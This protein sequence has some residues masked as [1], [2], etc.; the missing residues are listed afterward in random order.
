MNSS[1][2]PSP[3][4]CPEC[5]TRLAARPGGPICPTCV[6]KRAI[7]PTPSEYDPDVT[8]SMEEAAATSPAPGKVSSPRVRPLV[9]R[10]GS[11]V[12][13]GRGSKATS[14]AAT[15]SMNAEELRPGQV[16]GDYIIVKRL[17]HGGM[18]TVY[19]ADHQ[20]T[21][22][23]VALKVLTHAL[24]NPQ[25]RARF[26]REGRLAASINHP[27]SVYV[28]GTEEIGETPSISME[29]IRG[30]TLQQHIRAKGS[31]TPEAAVDAVLQI[32]DGL[33]AADQKGVLHRDVKPANC[34]VDP[35][36]VIK[37]GD[38][39][40][41]IST[42]AREDFSVTNVTREGVFLGTPA[43]ASPEQLRGEPLDL[44]SDIY[45]V[46]VTLFYLLT[47]TTPFSGE[48][49]VQLLATVLDKPAP[50]VSQFRPDVSEDLD[51]VL[52][53]CLEKSAGQ[54]FPSYDALREALV[55][56]SSQQPTPASLGTRLI[57][58][59]VDLVVISTLVSSVAYCVHWWFTGNVSFVPR[60]QG[61]FAWANVA[62]TIASIAV[63]LGYYAWAEWRYGTTLGKSVFRLR[64]LSAEQSRM[65][66]PQ[67]L[68]RAATFV[69]IP[70]LPSFA[71]S[72]YTRD[73]S[74]Q[75]L[76]EFPVSI[77]GVVVGVTFYILK[78]GMFLPA[79]EHNG[80]AGFH[81]LVSN[82][83][84]IAKPQLRKASVSGS[85]PEEFV[86]T[87]EV[88]KVGPYHVLKMIA[89][90]DQDR[91]QLGYD[92]KLLRRVWIREQAAG[93]A[94]V[95]TTARNLSRATRLRW[96]G[97]RRE[98]EQS[99]DCYEAPDGRPLEL[100]LR[101]GI[102][103][104][105]ITRSLQDLIDELMLACEES[106][107]PD[108][109]SMSQLWVAEDG[110][111]KLL[112]FSG[113]PKAYPLG[114]DAIVLSNPDQGAIKS[115]EFMHH[116][117]GRI[118]DQIEL[119]RESGGVT[120]AALS[121]VAT[122][123]AIASATSLDLVQRQIQS[124][125][126]RPLP[127]V[128]WRVA[129]MLAVSLFLPATIIVSSLL[130]GAAMESQKAKMPRI[131]ELARV[132]QLIDIEKRLATPESADR[133]KALKTYVAANY[134]DV[135][136]E[137]GDLDSLYGMLVIP[138]ARRTYFQ[139]ILDTPPPGEAA[140]EH[141][142][143]MFNE[144]NGEERQ[145]MPADISFLSS[146]GLAFLASVSWV[147]VV[148]IPS[149]VTAI[150]FRGGALLWV[151]GLTLV[152]RDGRPASRLRVLIRMLVGGIPAIAV[153]WLY[154]ENPLFRDSWTA[155]VQWV[156]MILVLL[157]VAMT[158][159]RKWRLPQDWI[160]GSYLVAR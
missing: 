89:G 128:R 159:F 141:A 22:R 115:L 71:F 14:A 133:V 97:G 4:Y 119:T 35:N 38:F 27:N 148:W 134:R 31:M 90:R 106:S 160:S 53:K 158:V 132:T 47:G 52:R 111:L 140:A 85:E 125:T 11:D 157:V 121:D 110:G 155:W 39:G 154:T 65:K 68:L 21:G 144:I 63:P 151:F 42:E 56:L 50:S 15:G 8:L 62:I 77:I 84:V 26:L 17:G 5:G 149:L 57:A 70:N 152:R 81:E 138:L 98:V 92:A 66:V 75:T 59:I 113:D 69:V 143:Q 3:K 37:I 124:L 25:A 36:G 116:V 18:G 6:M 94:A 1:Q 55:P 101:N 104:E 44:R 61:R 129:G 123:R 102:T 13:A 117:V 96:L 118:V 49:M 9:G 12:D 112:P 64:V 2:E 150:L 20:P 24:D 87:K 88:E 109:L 60:F 74:F 79:R 51:Q 32:I 7:E 108:V 127:A 67:A 145:I 29:L 95:D 100:A 107:L 10:V 80:Y 146:S 41:S 93:A 86:Q 16:F 40:L 137:K 103:F 156:I 28:Y 46:G 99:W 153:V 91:L 147:Q 43:F 54:R 142:R 78:I 126:R 45:S 76:Q 58:N 23:R 131:T 72:F 82:T 136:V 73:M 83:R 30:G 135:L 114:D 34:F 105:Q 122:L 120:G 33:E 19:E 130:V 48:N 139:Q